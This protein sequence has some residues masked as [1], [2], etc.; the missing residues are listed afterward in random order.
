MRYPLIALLI[1]L[2][3]LFGSFITPRVKTP[4]EAVIRGVAWCYVADYQSMKEY[5]QEK[6]LPH[7]LIDLHSK[8][9]TVYTRC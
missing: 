8:G 9:V 1:A 4:A 2:A 5:E 6:P 7:S 3:V